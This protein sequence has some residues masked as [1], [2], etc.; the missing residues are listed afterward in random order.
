MK[1]IIV[2]LF[3]VLGVVIVMSSCLPQKSAMAPGSTVSMTGTII[4]IENGKDG[5]MATIRDDR[6]VE[7][8]ATISIVNLQKTG[9]KY[10]RRN[11]GDKITVSGPYWKDN[12]GKVRITAELLR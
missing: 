3:L 10:V 12:N 8:I 11:V 4:N 5:Y 1:R 7:C 6:G 2:V 9:S